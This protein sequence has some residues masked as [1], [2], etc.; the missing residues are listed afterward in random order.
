[1]NIHFNVVIIWRNTDKIRKV[2]KRKIPVPVVSQ[3]IFTTSKR[4]SKTH[5][6]TYPN[7][8]KLIFFTNHTHQWPY[9][10]NLFRVL[11]TIN[12]TIIAFKLRHSMCVVC[13]QIL[14][15]YQQLFS[16]HVWFLI[17]YINTIE[18]IIIANSLFFK[19][20]VISIWHWSVVC[21]CFL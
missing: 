11:Y 9:K 12:I 20:Y 8:I 10:W 16:E 5:D 2:N 21:S 14:N 6:Q 7:T 13:V 19:I 18:I 1:M 4:Y 3:T 15:T 17:A